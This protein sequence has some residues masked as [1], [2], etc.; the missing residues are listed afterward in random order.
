M[1]PKAPQIGPKSKKMLQ[2]IPLELQNL[3]LDV[4]V[5]I[6]D[7][8]LMTFWTSG[9]TCSTLFLEY[10]LYARSRFERRNYRTNTDF[11]QTKNVETS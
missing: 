7:L 8:K 9:G 5:I 10:H 2:M 4:Q 3:I 1:A 11:A 6:L